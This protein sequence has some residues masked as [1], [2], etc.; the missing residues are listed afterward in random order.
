M[1][2]DVLRQLMESYIPFNKFL[3][4]R[5]GE[6]DRGRVRLEIPFRD[7]RSAKFRGPLQTPRGRPGARGWDR[8]SNLRFSRCG[9]FSGPLKL[10][11]A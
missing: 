3:G 10:K 9:W 1:E 5:L 4:I 11:P 8:G 2:A 6:M 7:E